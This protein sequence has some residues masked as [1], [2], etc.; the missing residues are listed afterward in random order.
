MCRSRLAVVVAAAVAV[1]ALV[2]VAAQPAPTHAID[3]ARKAFD[4]PPDDARVMMRWWWFGPATTEA[5]IARD[6]EAM[7]RAAAWAAPRSSRSIRWRSTTRRR[8]GQHALPVRRVP[9]RAAGRQRAGWR[10]RPAARP[11]A[12]QR[13]AVMAGP[14]SASRTRPAACGS[15][16]I[17][18]G[19][20]AP[21]VARPAMTTGETWIGAFCRARRRHAGH[22]GVDASTGMAR[23][24][25]CRR[26]FRPPRTRGRC[27]S[28]SPAAP[29]CR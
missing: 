9:R 18:V 6:L 1:A 29:G 4:T 25:R 17:V 22:A 27:G 3:D 16:R 20:G 23:R 13:V 24:R 21:R 8:R 19:P 28:S 11:H 5:Q 12:R 2:R 26:R 7:K 15:S 14:P 10:A